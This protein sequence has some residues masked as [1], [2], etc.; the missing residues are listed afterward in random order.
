MV[1][2]ATYNWLTDWGTFSLT[3][4]WSWVDEQTY[5]IWGLDADYGDSYHRTSAFL[6]WTHWEDKYRVI[7][8]GKNLEDDEN[9]NTVNHPITPTVDVPGCAARKS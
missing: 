4:Q 8:Y 9:Y 3:G 1:L 6:S 5:S 7:F 2:G